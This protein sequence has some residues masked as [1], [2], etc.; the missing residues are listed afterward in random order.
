MPAAYSEPGVV[1]TDPN[2]WIKENQRAAEIAELAKQTGPV[3]PMAD[4][5]R[6]VPDVRTAGIPDADW[7]Q[8]Q[9]DTVTGARS[10]GDEFQYVPDAPIVDPSWAPSGGPPYIYNSPQMQA[11]HL[12]HHG[13]ERPPRY[14]THADKTAGDYS[15]DDRGLTAKRAEEMEEQWAT[16]QGIKD[17]RKHF[18]SSEVPTSALDQVISPL[19]ANEGKVVN[20]RKLSPRQVEAFFG[21]PYDDGILP[22]QEWPA[23][24]AAAPAAAAPDTATPSAAAP[25][26]AATTAASQGSIDSRL[27]AASGL[28]EPGTDFPIG[29]FEDSP[30]DQFTNQYLTQV[31]KRKKFIRALSRLFGVPDRSTEYETKAI[32]KFTQFMDARAARYAVGSRPRDMMELASAYLKAGGTLDGLK[33]LSSVISFDKGKDAKA[34]QQFTYVVD[35]KDIGRDPK[36]QYT[37]TERF[38]FNTGQLTI[39]SVS[40][41]KEKEHKQQLRMF[42]AQRVKER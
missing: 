40:E 31:P 28:S 23:P 14:G 27:V 21:G 4:S 20:A 13:R 7:A 38:N 15:V 5:F 24:S 35:G 39:N 1:S 41:K 10:A 17:H 37:V 16:R 3:G 30:V 26:A 2:I 25:A 29:V 42:S 9:I 18:P 19:F 22:L 6:Y 32:A 8:R 34:P 33:S 12:R 36:K 11:Q